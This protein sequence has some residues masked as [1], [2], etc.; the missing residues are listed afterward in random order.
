VVAV[1]G[2]TDRLLEAPLVAAGRGTDCMPLA[3]RGGTIEFTVAIDVG[4]GGAWIGTTGGT[5]SALRA[6]GR[7]TDGISVGTGEGDA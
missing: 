3:G 6:A 4:A 5:S 7:G 2:R 1:C